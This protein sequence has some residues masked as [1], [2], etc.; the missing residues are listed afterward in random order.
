MRSKPT[1]K[2][3][4]ALIENLTAAMKRGGEFAVDMLE[5]L[6]DKRNEP[7]CCVTDD[8]RESGT[9]QKNLVA[10]YITRLADPEE[11]Q[12]FGRVLT[13]ALAAEAAGN[14]LYIA[15]LDCLAKTPAHQI[16]GVWRA[17]LRRDLKASKTK[18]SRAEV[19]NG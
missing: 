15:Y 13:E 7:L 11:V 18:A 2:R 10:D 9:P 1:Q 3:A 16:D 5:E 6:A 14:T 12:G 19:A 4:P 8:W 17:R